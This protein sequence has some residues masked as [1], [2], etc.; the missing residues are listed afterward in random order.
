MH[1]GCSGRDFASG[2]EVVD[3]LRMMGFGSGMIPEPLELDCQRCGALMRMTTFEFACPACGAVHGVTPCH[4]SSPRH[5]R[6]AGPGY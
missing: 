3:K 4:A 5:V 6:C 2:R 1:D